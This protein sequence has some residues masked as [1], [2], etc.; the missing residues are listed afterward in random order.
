MIERAC[1]FVAQ[2][3]PYITIPAPDKLPYLTRYFIMGK[4][5]PGINVFL[6]HFHQSDLD[7]SPENDSL[8]L[9]NHTWKNSVSLILFGGYSE[10]RR[11]G[12]SLAVIRREFKPGSVNHISNKDFH[13]VDLFGKDG[14]SLFITSKRATKDARWS[15]WDRETKVET[16]AEEMIKRMGKD[17]FIP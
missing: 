4:E 15:F 17:V 2:F 10:E 8:L 11:V 6:H 7:R 13:R 14:W 16:D 12:K 9:H 1:K 3:L 5:R